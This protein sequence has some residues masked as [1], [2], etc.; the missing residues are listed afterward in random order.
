LTK[1]LNHYG[2]RIEVSL[3]DWGFLEADRLKRAVEFAPMKR[4]RRGLFN[5][6][7]AMSVL[8]CLG[9]AAL[10]AYS[11]FYYS[12]LMYIAPLGVQ[13]DAWGWEI[14]SLR[15]RV[16]VS[17]FD[18]PSNSLFIGSSIFPGF[19]LS[20]REEAAPVIDWPWLAGS[21]KRVG[22]DYGNV[23]TIGHGFGLAGFYWEHTSFAQQVD[24]IF[25]VPDWF[26]MVVFLIAPIRWLRRPTWH[27][28]GY[29]A[30]CGYDL[31]ATP[32]RCP[33]CGKIVYKTI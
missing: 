22:N 4:F 15:G 9:T 1:T 8:L 5:A 10:W 11:T 20:T 16:G 30:S 25:A 28:E 3:G 23:H 29:C 7:V 14:S 33:E 21:T 17:K 26:L 6:I 2:N 12:L 27:T 18:I 32:D 24:N 13:G 19:G 31:R